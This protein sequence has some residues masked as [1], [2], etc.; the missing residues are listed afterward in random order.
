M[1]QKTAQKQNNLEKMLHYILGV[2]PDEFGLHPNSEGFVPL[3]ALLSAL[4]D[5][6]GFRGVREGQLTMLANQPKGQAQ[7][8]IIDGDIRLKPELASLPPEAPEANTLP[9]LLYL[10][11]KM[12]AWA[13][14]SERGLSPKTGDEVVRLWASQEQAA[15]LAKRLS[16]NAVVVTVRAQ[17]A[18]QGGALLQ[19]YSERLWLT[20]EINS[21]FLTGPPIPPK[22]ETAPANKGKKES[23]KEAGSFPLSPPPP[24]SV[25]TH[26][27][28]KPGKYSDEPDWK[29]QT[30][31]E[32]RRH[33]RD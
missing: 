26:K 25:E 6:E 30:R 32:R 13:V 22:E 14:I 1:A 9:K 28:K 7:V 27:G 18:K 10:P 29:K 8:D 19:P 2:Q 5:E 12:A 4:G 3:K 20:T 33:E 31:R 24:T 16:A 21:Q 17:A 15:K 11:L 23:L